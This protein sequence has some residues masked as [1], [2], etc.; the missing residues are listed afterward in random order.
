MLLHDLE[1]PINRSK[2]KLLRE[3]PSMTVSNKFHPFTI[4]IIKLFIRW[5]FVGQIRCPYMMCIVQT[6]LCN[7]MPVSA[8]PFQSIVY[9]TL[10]WIH[11][12][13]EL[14]Y[15]YNLHHPIFIQNRCFINTNHKNIAKDI[16]L[17]RG[18]T[19]LKNKS[20]SIFSWHRITN[21]MITVPDW[22]V[23]W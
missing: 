16:K 10:K 6:K 4:V 5:W 3:Y 18:G 15:G 14:N 13:M 20:Y 12:L 7:I 17:W 11:F 21:N 22:H 1:T 9:P 19:C 23:E 2:C 8:R